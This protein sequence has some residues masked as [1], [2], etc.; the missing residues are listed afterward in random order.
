MEM[1]LEHQP[2]IQLPESVKSGLARV[3]QLR[4]GET[5]SISIQEIGQDNIQRLYLETKRKKPNM[6]FAHYDRDLDVKITNAEVFQQFEGNDQKGPNEYLDAIKD[7]SLKE[8]LSIILA[9]ATENVDLNAEERTRISDTV[10]GIT[11][12]NLR[13]AYFPNASNGDWGNTDNLIVACVDAGNEFSNNSAFQ[14]A[15]GLVTRES[16]IH[17]STF[18]VD[19]NPELLDVILEDF[20]PDLASNNDKLKAFEDAMIDA[21]WFS[22]NRQELNDLQ[23]LNPKGARIAVKILRE[24]ATKLDDKNKLVAAEYFMNLVADYK[25]GNTDAQKQ[26]EI[27]RLIGDKYETDEVYSFFTQ[28]N[29]PSVYGLAKIWASSW[30]KP[31]H[32]LYGFWSSLA[33]KTRGS[34]LV[35]RDREIDTSDMRNDSNP[36][37]YAQAIVKILKTPQKNLEKKITKEQTARLHMCPSCYGGKSGFESQKKIQGALSVSDNDNEKGIGSEFDEKRVDF[38]VEVMQKLRKDG[39]LKMKMEA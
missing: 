2:R 7:P 13:L 4:Q 9:V 11:N 1:T 21:T 10:R 22:E 17:S 6:S 34:P 16:M 38:A 24:N 30:A 39:Y 35:I 27:F 20:N 8:N 18:N 26:L 14:R 36:I 19:K 3:D 31:V 12:K 25:K 29:D 15:R 37:E 5:I 33:R 23:E 28:Y 32:K